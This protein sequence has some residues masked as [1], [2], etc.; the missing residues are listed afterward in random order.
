[1]R[2][3][4]SYGRG[5]APAYLHPCLYMY[6]V[7]LRVRVYLISNLILMF[8]QDKLQCNITVGRLTY[9]GH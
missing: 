8:V 5:S 3:L 1:M 4:G 6:V 9:E 2:Q 7:F